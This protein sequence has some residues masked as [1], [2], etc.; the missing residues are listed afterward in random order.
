MSYTRLPPEDSRCILRKEFFQ[1]IQRQAFESGK[2]GVSVNVVVGRIML[3]NTSNLSLFSSG[4]LK[5][6][7]DEWKRGN[8]ERV[9]GE[10]EQAGR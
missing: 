7:Y 8:D 6:L 5:C 9:S 1:K 2:S 3:A 4:V 10:N